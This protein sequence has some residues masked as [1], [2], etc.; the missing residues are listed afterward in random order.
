MPTD[1]F[2]KRAAGNALV[3]GVLIV[4]IGAGLVNDDNAAGPWF[5]GTGVVLAIFGLSVRGENKRV[6]R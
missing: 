5:V 2:W 1:N 4:L 3:L 6:D